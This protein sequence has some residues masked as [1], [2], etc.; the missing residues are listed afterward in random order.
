M[1]SMNPTIIWEVKVFYLIGVVVLL[2]C[3][4]RKKKGAV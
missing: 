3:M 1:M 2:G 4:V